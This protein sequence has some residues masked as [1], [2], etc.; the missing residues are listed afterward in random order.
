MVNSEIFGKKNKWVPLL[1]LNKEVR[2]WNILLAKG[3]G[4]VPRFMPSRGGKRNTRDLKL[5]L[6][7]VI[8]YMFTHLQLHWLNVV[9][10][11]FP[12]KKSEVYRA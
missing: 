9:L 8:K 2:L 12:R 3:K 10:V 7:H 4:R 11:Q 1:V 6:D 5:D